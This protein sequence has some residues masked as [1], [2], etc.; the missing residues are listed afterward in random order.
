MVIGSTGSRVCGYLRA[1]GRS[2]NL[3]QIYD[4]Q[5]SWSAVGT[6]ILAVTYR[7]N[8]SEIHVMDADGNS[9]TRLTNNGAQDID[10]DW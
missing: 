7:F 5:P 1:I 4:L 8:G 9:L 6:K 2:E 10:P 3:E